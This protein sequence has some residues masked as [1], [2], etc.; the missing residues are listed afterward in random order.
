MILCYPCELTGGGDQWL[1][2]KI[3]YLCFFQASRTMVSDRK[4]EYRLVDLDEPLDWIPPTRTFIRL[5]VIV[6]YLG[7]PFGIGYVELVFVGCQCSFVEGHATHFPCVF[8][9]FYGLSY[10][11][12]YFVI[13]LHNKTYSK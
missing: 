4:I 8:H 10:S 1:V 12:G 9:V 11:Y 3:G 5:G 6:I 13:L 7:I 2:L